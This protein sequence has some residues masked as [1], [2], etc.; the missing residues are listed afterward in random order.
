M[1]KNIYTNCLLITT[2]FCSLHSYAQSEKVSNKKD[3]SKP[4]IIYIFA[5]DLGYGELGAYGQKH[6]KT[7]NLDLL[8]KQGMSFS[9][10]Y[11]GSPV[12]APS[13]A[14]LLTAQHTG[15]GQIKDNYELGDFTDEGENG[16]MPLKPSTFTVADMLKQGGYKTAAI[17]KWGLGGPGSG[18]EPSDFGFDLFFGY[19]DQKQAHNYYPTHLWKNGKKVSLDNK[20]INPH[21]AFTGDATNPEDFKKY[22]GKEYSVDLMTAEA[23]DFIKDN[24]DEPFFLYLAY[25]IPHA[26]LQLPDEALKSYEGQFEETAYLGDNMYIPHMKPRAAYA[27]MITLMD[28]H[29]GRILNDLKKLGLEENTIVMF[30]SDNGPTYV[31]GVDVE[32]FDSTTGLKGLKGSVYEGGIRVPMI[33]KWPGKIKANSTSN[34]ISAVWDLMPTL[35]DLLKLDYPKDIDGES[36]LPSLLGEQQQEHAP[37]YWEYHGLEDGQQAVRMGK[38]K[39]VVLG[40]HKS[41]QARLELYN[42]DLDRSEENDVASKY[43]DIVSQIRKVMESRTPSEIKEW[44][45]PIK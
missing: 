18:S 28:D 27:G 39:G 15:S 26:P 43:P 23:Q 1:K 13:R 5:D 17:G 34:H 8:A 9:Q 29:I 35:G 25:P 19:L 31:S 24:K 37:L 11:S 41:E 21:Q 33:A 30:S 42:L 7:P 36:F 22:K 3:T 45:F 40:G 44:N 10:H 14:T 20:W 2:I 38:W 6:I 4:N 16:Q 32:F 12:C